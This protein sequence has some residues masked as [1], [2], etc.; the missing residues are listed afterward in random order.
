MNYTKKSNMRK[1]TKM[2]KY[3]QNVGHHCVLA[4]ENN[5]IEDLKAKYSNRKYWDICLA[6][7]KPRTKYILRTTVIIFFIYLFK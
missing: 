2:R 3:F 5:Y 6:S 4:K 1:K 7:P